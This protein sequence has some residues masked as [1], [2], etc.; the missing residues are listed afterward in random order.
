[1]AK[2]KMAGVGLFCLLIVLFIFRE[3]NPGVWVMRDIA[4]STFRECVE[5]IKHDEKRFTGP[6][7]D[8]TGEG[9]FTFVWKGHCKDS[10]DIE[11]VVPRVFPSFRT[12]FAGLKNQEYGSPGCSG[13]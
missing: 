12:Y 9:D 13:K 5:E 2:V 4:W 6:E 11:V 7:V 3:I 10:L 8:V 1:V